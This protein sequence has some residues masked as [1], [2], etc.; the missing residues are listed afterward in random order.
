[1]P[2]SSLLQ[3]T[4][5][6]VQ[7]EKN[8]FLCKQ[9]HKGNPARSAYNGIRPRIPCNPPAFA[10]PDSEKH[11][12]G[13]RIS[14]RAWK[15]YTRNHGIRPFVHDPVLCPA[16]FK[17]QRQFPAHK[18][19]HYSAQGN[20]LHPRVFPSG[21]SA[22]PCTEPHLLHCCTY[23]RHAVQHQYHLGNPDGSCSVL[24]LC[25]SG[26]SLRKCS[27]RKAG[28]RHLRCTAYELL[29]LALGHLVRHR[30]AG[31]GNQDLRKRPSLHPRCRT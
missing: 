17:G 6:E 20:R 21:A 29:S 23:S 31:Q 11:S 27:D 15:A 28:R 4:T 26:T 25:G 7:D 10:Y 19:L 30:Y 16:D 9:N 22:L 8:A 3:A 18:A 24:L 13:S 2:S 14:I 5:K 12:R 1:M